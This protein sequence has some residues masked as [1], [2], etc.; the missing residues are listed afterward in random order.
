MAFGPSM[1]TLTSIGFAPAAMPLK[2]AMSTRRSRTVASSGCWMRQVP[3]VATV[4][5]PLG[6]KPLPRLATGRAPRSASIAGGAPAR[7]M[8]TNATSAHVGVDAVG[9]RGQRAGGRAER[10]GGRQAGGAGRVEDRR[11]PGDRRR[12]ADAAD[13]RRRPGDDTQPRE[14]LD[15]VGWGVGARGG[16][17]D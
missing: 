8:T 12:A 15:R 5:P 16:A 13:V 1:A 11:E 9:D 6:P 7:G 4:S 14:D 2:L 17:A 10:C 3:A